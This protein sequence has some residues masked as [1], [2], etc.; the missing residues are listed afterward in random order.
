MS[1]RRYSRSVD[2]T[3]PVPALLYPDE[4]SLASREGVGIYDGTEKSA[5]HQSGTIYVTTH[6]L[7]Y[8]D[9]AHPETRSFE[10]DLAHVQKTEYYAGLFTSSPK[11]TLYLYPLRSSSSA[12]A[13]MGAY[14]GAVDDPAF[15]SWTCDVCN[16]RNPPGLSPA[17]SRIC[18][19]CGVPRPSTQSSADGPSNASS[20][21]Y[22]LSL[23]LPSSSV[24][25]SQL[26]SSSSSSPIP[27]HL[28]QDG[29]QEVA[30]VVCTFL[31]HPDLTRC[32]MCGSPLPRPQPSVQL[33]YH[34]HAKSAPA[35]RPAT[36]R[37]HDGSDSPETRMIRLSFRK[38]G[39]K[40]FY[41]VLKRSLLG[42]GWE[43]K[44]LKK[45]VG[46]T[47]AA[48]AATPSAAFS[49]ING[50]LRSVETTAA[51]TQ[52]DMEN[53]LKDLEALMV[54][55]KDM[56]KLAQD[57]N[58]RLTA[59]SSSTPVAPTAT[60]GAVT[61][62]DGGM[63]MITQ[64]VEP[65]EATFIRSSLAQLGLQMTNAPVTLDM[66]KDEQKWMEELAKEL[67]QVL[68]GD[69][70]PGSREGMMRKRGIIGLD[71]VWGGWNRARGVALI[72]P[73]TFL[74]VV[75]RLQTYTSPPIC[76]RTF[77]ASGFSVLHIPEYALL[78]FNARLDNNLKS[79]G[80]KTVVE[81][82]Q[83]EGLP[84]G[85]TQEMVNDAEGDSFIC[86]DEGGSGVN[87]TANTA[88]AWRG[89]ASEGSGEVRY[90]PNIFRDYVWDG[91]ED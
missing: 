51:T 30:C 19:L 49:G 3:I 35:S 27:P 33:G 81:I 47:N 69:D 64:A 86:R 80:P 45:T 41:A 34:P 13:P 75:P 72:P 9:A 29:S 54:K 39:D 22:H 12:D 14:D 61:S 90:W 42:K 21:P 5:P 79:H 17:A 32:E 59:A 20:S 23:S 36:P 85:L 38:G 15:K 77:R 53:A 43:I 70:G 82:A 37:D 71:E 46:S 6:R 52:T 50:I 25:L 18:G 91:Q 87:V 55:W 76:M 83:E 26:T 65:E 48:S 84:I 67:A 63:T 8:I 78:E 62:I 10:L 11:V 1:L 4:E 16:Y 2:G 73:S 31:N 57:L 24:D 60:A 56:V 66:I 40:A 89:W 7:F 88:G 68:Q 28:L 74:E 58:E 44:S